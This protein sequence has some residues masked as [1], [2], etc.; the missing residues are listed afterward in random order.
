MTVEADFSQ[1]AGPHDE[2]DDAPKS[3][4]TCDF[5]EQIM[6]SVTTDLTLSEYGGS[7]GDYS[8]NGTMS[9]IDSDIERMSDITRMAG[10]YEAGVTVV[11]NSGNPLAA[12]QGET[13]TITWRALMLSPGEV[14]AL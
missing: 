14:I 12:D 10:V 4:S 2:V 5:S 6:A 3:T 8:L 1:T 9:Q 7:V 11:S 13:V